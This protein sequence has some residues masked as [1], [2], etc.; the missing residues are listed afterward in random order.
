[1]RSGGDGNKSK[2]KAKAF[3]H[4]EEV[5]SA[6]GERATGI[7]SN[8]DAETVDMGADRQCPKQ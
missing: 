3:R 8:N 2:R 4:L 6:D 7:S 5:E 1:M